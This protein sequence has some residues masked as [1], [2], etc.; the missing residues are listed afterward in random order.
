[1]KIVELGL[2]DS[3]DG[4]RVGGDTVV[5]G[6]EY[7]DEYSGPIL[8]AIVDVAGA[9]GV[10]TGEYSGPMLGTTVDVTNGI[11]VVTGKLIS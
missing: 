5:G 11:G 1:M 6:E 2:V 10:V 7:T 9:F 4:I 3:L 8:G